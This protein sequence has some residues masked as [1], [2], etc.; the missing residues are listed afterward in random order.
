MRFGNNIIW[1]GENI[2]SIENKLKELNI[3]L[4]LPNPPGAVYQPGVL[5]G[6]FIFTAG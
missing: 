6:N 3:V 4:P 2:M 5:A 1:K